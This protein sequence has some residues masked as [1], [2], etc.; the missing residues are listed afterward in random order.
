MDEIVFDMDLDEILE[1]RG[2]LF[3]DLVDRGA[4]QYG[5]DRPATPKGN[6]IDIPYQNTLRPIMIPWTMIRR[7]VPSIAAEDLCDLYLFRLDPSKGFPAKMLRRKALNIA[8]MAPL[9]DGMPLEVIAEQEDETGIPSASPVGIQNSEEIIPDI[10]LSDSRHSSSNHNETSVNPTVDVNQSTAIIEQTPVQGCN[11]D[12][13][14]TESSQPYLANNLVR[15][16]PTDEPEGE[17]HNSLTCDNMGSPM[18]IS[19]WGGGDILMQENAVLSQS[20]SDPQGH[21]AH[22]NHS[23]DAQSPSRDSCSPLRVVT[24]HS[25]S[26]SGNIMGD[27]TQISR[28]TVVDMQSEGF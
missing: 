20:I 28:T 26:R 27:A 14:E 6:M 4:I 23:L 24:N 16:N 7:R 21:T 9:S 3:T 17:E 12:R 18:P 10:T 5:A 19:V 11:V 1:A 22:V 8:K 13:A 2:A 15:V 25:E